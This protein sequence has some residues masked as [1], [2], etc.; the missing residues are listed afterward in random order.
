M[1]ARG[2]VNMN[3]KKR[4]KSFTR[5]FFSVI[6][7]VLLS[8]SIAVG[9]TSSDDTFSGSVLSDIQSSMENTSASLNSL[10]KKFDAFLISLVETNANLMFQFDAYLSGTA[11]K[12]AQLAPVKAITESEAVTKTH[13]DIQGKLAEIPY[14]AVKSNSKAYDAYKQI[15]LNMGGITENIRIQVLAEQEGSDSLTLSDT[16]NSTANLLNIGGA[17]SIEAKL[18]SVDYSYDF[19][20]LILP[21]SYLSDT[22]TAAA[23]NFITYL[24][25]KY[26][27]VNSL[28][29]AKI[30]ADNDKLKILENY[31]PYQ[32]Y[33]VSYRSYLANLSIPLSN[34]YQM[35]SERTKL[36]DI[37]KNAENSGVT[38]SDEV[39]NT[40]TDLS[41]A[42][43]NSLLDLQNYVANHRVNDPVWHQKMESASPTTVQRETL[44]VLSEIESQLH[45]LHMDNERI[46][47]TL[48][49]QQL[50]DVQNNNDIDASDIQEYVD[51]ELAN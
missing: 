7:G 3:I 15:L 26:K 41:S 22:Q 6:V 13:G 10:S 46:L 2:L 36:S 11:E 37:I 51:T 32:V 27:T 30:R 17:E 34:F 8:V 33:L 44:F 18:K 40:V 19:D 39:K 16:S 50:R 28:N 48:S 49:A 5:F 9:Q 20:S 23:N 21:S 29:L 24:T 45:R 4:F 1:T 47:A 14:T 42:N 31:P 35:L 12:T 25:Q 43:I 38:V